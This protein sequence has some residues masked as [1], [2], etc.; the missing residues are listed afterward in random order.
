MRTAD[1]AT[2]AALAALGFAV[3]GCDRGS[4]PETRGEARDETRGEARDDAAIEASPVDRPAFAMTWFEDDY[5]S[6][7]AAARERRKPLVVLMWAR[8]CNTCL[9]MH[10]EV[11]PDP[12]LEVVA[13]RFVWLKIDTDR[14]INA[15]VLEKLSIEVWPT[16][17]V[18][19]PDGAVQARLTSAAS[20]E[21]FRDFLLEGERL[22]LDAELKS[23][24]LDPDSPLVHAA[25]GD[26]ALAQNDFAAARDA[27][28]R[29]L[30]LAPEAW[31]RRP[32][33]LVSLLHAWMRAGDTNDC[34]RIAR[35]HIRETGKSA[36]AVRFSRHVQI[37]GQAQPD[38]EARR[39]LL[40]LAD[41]WLAEISEGEHGLSSDDQST[42][43]RTRRQIQDE[44]GDAHAARE[45][46]LR[47]RE[48]LDRAAAAAMGP[49]AAA[50]YSWPRAEV[51]AYLGE[52]AALLPALIELAEA[53][54]DEYDPPSRVAWLALQAGELDT[55]RVW[56][57]RAV[58][59]AYGPRK[60][61]LLEQL[62]EIYDEAG[63][64]D[65]KQEV[66]EDLAAHLASLPASQPVIR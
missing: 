9:S 21:Q 50:T 30:E 8:W 53:L 15:P 12:G 65:R 14:A 34:L 58:E 36:S 31:P 43:L 51:Y 48:L 3:A 11:L 6:A 35:R 54:P 55:A 32:D 5:A 39:E 23:G 17:Y 19:S 24:E 42:A 28:E 2:V 37:C 26:R 1:S 62:A 38:A 18:L 60:A 57:E 13:D 29:A 56:G 40:L 7:L 22:H 10:N 44:L 27:Y 46:A 52:P 4:G 49:Y 47:Q 16:S 45:L 64:L 41:G 63:D 20:V 33:V 59:L 25:A 61:L 66:L